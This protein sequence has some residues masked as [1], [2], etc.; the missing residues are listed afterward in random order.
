MRDW[1]ADIHA[2]ALG[3]MEKAQELSRPS[4]GPEGD[5]TNNSD[6]APNGPDEISDRSPVQQLHLPFFKSIKSVRLTVGQVVF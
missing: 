2:G 6:P 1:V 3:E 4:L 5:G